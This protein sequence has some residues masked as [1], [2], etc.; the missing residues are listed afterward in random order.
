MMKRTGSVCGPGRPLITGSS[1]KTQLYILKIKPT[2]RATKRERAVPGS[3]CSVNPNPI[4]SIKHSIAIDINNTQATFNDI[5]SWFISY[6]SYDKIW[7][8]QIVILSCLG[9]RWTNLVCYSWLRILWILTTLILHFDYLDHIVLWWV[10]NLIDH[11]G[12][13]IWAH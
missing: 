7:G 4:P 2:K 12:H 5:I 10:F 1:M 13:I 3:S 9:Q 6:E 11:M 8:R